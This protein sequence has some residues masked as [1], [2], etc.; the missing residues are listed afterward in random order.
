[1]SKTLHCRHALITGGAAGI[2]L[3]LAKACLLRGAKITVVDIA[4]DTSTAKAELASCLSCNLEGALQF[5]RAD[6]GA[7]DQVF[8]TT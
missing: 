5:Y 8:A 3:A 2:G 7:Y 4:A 6:V 1:M